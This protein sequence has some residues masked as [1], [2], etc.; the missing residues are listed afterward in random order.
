MCKQRRNHNDNLQNQL[1]RY[2]AALLFRELL[3]RRDVFGS[4]KT[5]Q[6]NSGDMNDGKNP[7][8]IGDIYIYIYNF[9]ED[10]AYTFI[11]LEIC[12]TCN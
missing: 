11:P 12:P 5:D 10:F 6:R 3:G 7:D 9:F 1:P 4:Q 8:E 2:V